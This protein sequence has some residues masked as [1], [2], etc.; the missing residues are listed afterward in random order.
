[1]EREIIHKEIDLIQSCINRMAHNSFLLKGWTISIIAV[2]LALADKASSP[3]LLALILLIPILGFWY[4]DAFFLRTERMYRKMYE[5]VLEKRKADDESFLYDLNPRRFE[6]Q[7]ESTGKIMWSKTLRTFY[8]IPFAITLAV[9]A[10]R[11]VQEILKRGS[12][13]A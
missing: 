6:D 1:M 2:I 5:W 12:L 3:G 9:V 10:V 7:V 4:L 13:L 8:G 11:I